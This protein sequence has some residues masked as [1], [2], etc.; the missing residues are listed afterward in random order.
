M[1]QTL[2]IQISTKTAWVIGFQALLLLPEQQITTTFVPMGST[3]DSNRTWI[4]SS[5]IST[6]LLLVYEQPVHKAEHDG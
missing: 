3:S 6:F 2:Y 5:A 4:D 1:T